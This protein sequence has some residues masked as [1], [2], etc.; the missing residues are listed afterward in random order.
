MLRRL[1]PHL[2]ARGINVAF[3]WTEFHRTVT[4]LVEVA[5]PETV[6]DL[7]DLA[8]APDQPPRAGDPGG[9]MT[10]R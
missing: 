10:H 9:E 6:T 3:D 5:A 7:A 2:R 4:L 8:N 1:I